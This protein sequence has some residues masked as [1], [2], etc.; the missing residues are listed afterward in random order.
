MPFIKEKD[1]V[2]CVTSK[3]NIFILFKSIDEH[4]VYKFLHLRINHVYRPLSKIVHV[5]VEHHDTKKST[6]ASSKLSSKNRIVYGDTNSF[7]SPL[8]NS[9]TSEFDKSLKKTASELVEMF[10]AN[11]ET[12]KWNPMKGIDQTGKKIIGIRLD[13][14][15][16]RT[17][18]YPIQVMLHQGTRK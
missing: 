1:Y 8:N 12:D 2:L 6:K 14:P 3:L 10:I 15:R 17:F 18:T 9:N 5:I 13:P 16:I 7:I 4:N 11:T